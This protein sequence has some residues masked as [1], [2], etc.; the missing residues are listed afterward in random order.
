MLSSYFGT[1]LRA[2]F[3]LFTITL[4]WYIFI[5]LIYT[6]FSYL[7]FFEFSLLIMNGCFLLFILFRIFY[8]KNVFI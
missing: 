3:V 4:F 1:V 2:F 7:F 8:P 5:L 6:I